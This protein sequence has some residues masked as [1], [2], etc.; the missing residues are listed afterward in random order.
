METV[1]SS[2]AFLVMGDVLERSKFERRFKKGDA[3]IVVQSGEA[4]KAQMEA[5]ELDGLDGWQKGKPHTR[6]SKMSRI[7]IGSGHLFAWWMMDDE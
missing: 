5:Q 2:P 6:E 7:M 4:A 1:Q 3:W